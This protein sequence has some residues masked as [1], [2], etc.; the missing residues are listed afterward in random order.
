MGSPRVRSMPRRSSQ[1]VW[2]AA[3]VMAPPGLRGA[4]MTVKG[5]PDRRV[6]RGRAPTVSAISA[7]AFGRR[8]ELISRQALDGAVFPHALLSPA[9]GSG[10]FA[11]LFAF[12]QGRRHADQDL[13]SVRRGSALFDGGR[14]RGP[15]QAKMRA[16][17]RARV[18]VE[19]EPEDQ[20]QH[21]GDSRCGCDQPRAPAPQLGE[22]KGA[23]NLFAKSSPP[24]RGPRAS[25]AAAG[26]RGGR[27]L[28]PRR[29]QR[30]PPPPRSPA[31]Q[32]TRGGHQAAARGPVPCPRWKPAHTARHAFAN[33]FSD[34]HELG[35]TMAE[36]SAGGDCVPSQILRVSGPFIRAIHV[37]ADM[38]HRRWPARS[39]RGG[40]QWAQA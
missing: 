28:R 36:R 19:H 25:G 11:R 8:P 3:G 10:I 22:W 21:R 7:S 14:N 27:S 13:A 33:P 24:W 6:R 39:Y 37:H 34:G 9:R 38:G 17:G 16:R 23:R 20:R 26:P 4:S 29:N 5:A 12:R 35:L 31:G 40:T 1:A 2:V 32:H 15:L 30:T 18:E